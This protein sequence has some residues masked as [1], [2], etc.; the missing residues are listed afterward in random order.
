MTSWDSTRTRL[1]KCSTR[2]DS[3]N[4]ALK[5]ARDPEDRLSS[6]TST[7]RLPHR[8]H[9][10][11]KRSWQS[12]RL[13][14]ESANLDMLIGLLT[15]DVFISMPPMPFEYEGRD[16]VAR[17]CANLFDAGR[18]YD[19]V[20]DAGE[21]STGLRGL[22]TRRHRPAPWGRPVSSSP[23]PVTGSAQ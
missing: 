1:L 10:P 3:V 18:R 7:K 12:S 17:F 4:S 11:R 6:D 16:V 22:P 9:E 19:L 21:W 5:R 13:A 2:L 15:D 20:R 8:T 14:W 23:S